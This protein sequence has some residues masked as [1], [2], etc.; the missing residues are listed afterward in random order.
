MIAEDPV[1]VRME[2]LVKLWEAQAD[3]RSAFLR[4]YLMMTRN[5]L[6]AITEGEFYDAGWVDHL[7]HRFADY[8]FNAL[9]A[10]ERDRTTAPAVW[11]VAH[12]VTHDPHVF[13]LE[14]VLLGINAHINFDLVLSLVDMLEAEWAD[15]NA[16]RRQERY[17]DHCHVNK[18]IGRT[19]DAVQ[20]QILEPAMPLL[21]LVDVLMGRADEKLV[22]R[23]IASWREVCWH[24]ATALLDAPD[25]A[26]RSRLVSEV[27][28]VALRHA[29][30]L[31]LHNLPATLS[32][33][34]YRQPV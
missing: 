11:Q 21:K 4:C 9:D 26:E 30:G 24:H 10:Y 12:N 31:R 27:E 7:L 5:M 22:S 2:S 16:E 1:V 34:L 28:A 3:Q 14:K 33:V 19:I 17:L 8:Y 29:A 20:D 13:L 15:L 18:V 6:A 23:L 25:A 32:E